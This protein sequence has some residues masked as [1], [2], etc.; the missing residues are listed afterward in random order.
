MPAGF[1][2]DLRPRARR[3]RSSNRNGARPDRLR[4]WSGRTVDPSFESSTEVTS[5][6][7]DV[8]CFGSPPSNADRVQV[9]V[10]VALAL[11]INLVAILQ[12]AERLRPGPSSQASSCSV[13]R[14]R[15]FARGGIERQNPAI[16][17]IGRARDHHG[18]RALFVPQRRL[19]LHFAISQP[20]IDPLRLHRS[21]RRESPRAA[22]PAHRRRWCGRDLF[23]VRRFG[24]VVRNV[25]R[26]RS[27]G[28]LR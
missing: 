4:W 14:V 12:P 9:R 20:G 15:V 17:V 1:L 18:L 7:P 25:V 21:R 23:G 16:F 11:E 22:D 27:V 3:R 6:L 13:N 19:H 5:N 28:A 2:G 26:L 8:N 10:A 24:D